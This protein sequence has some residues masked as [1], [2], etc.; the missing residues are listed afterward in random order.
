MPIVQVLLIAIA[1]SMDAMAVSIGTCTRKNAPSSRSMLVMA[2]SFGVF[3]AIMPLLGYSLGV[4]GAKLLQNLDH[5]LA[6]GLLAFVGSKMIYEGICHKEE[7]GDPEDLVAGG[8]VHWHTLLVLSVATS[9]D[10]AAVGLS[11]SLIHSEILLP[12]ILIGIVTFSLSWM[13]GHFGRV[14]GEKMGVAA[15]I[16]GGI[17][18]W[19]IGLKILLGHLL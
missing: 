6:F 8:H 5:W 11:F 15:E 19:G 14:L 2:I 18:L 13:G 7:D 10:A 16:F 4:L 3:Q 17:V 9:I 12:S 1:L